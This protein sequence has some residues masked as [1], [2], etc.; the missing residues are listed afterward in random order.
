[1]SYLFIDVIIYTLFPGNCEWDGG[2]IHATNYAEAMARVPYLGKKRRERSR[3]WGRL[4]RR[5]SQQRER[6]WQWDGSTMGKKL[7]AV[8][9]DDGEEVNSGGGLDLVHTTRIYEEE[10]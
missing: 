3:R 10:R 4:S 1:M 6:S 7:A 2:S 9:I 5:R 8:W